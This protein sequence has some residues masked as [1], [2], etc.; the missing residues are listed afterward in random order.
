MGR[1]SAPQMPTPRQ[2]REAAE[3]V[4]AIHPGARIARVGPEGIEFH[5]PDA[6]AAPGGEWRGKPFSAEGA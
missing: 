1:A 6:A 5:Y 3:A 2:I 4:A